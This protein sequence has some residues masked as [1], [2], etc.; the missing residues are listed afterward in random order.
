SDEVD[1]VL[2]RALEK[3]FEDARRPAPYLSSCD[4]ELSLKF[5]SERVT[6]GITATN[7]G[8][9]GPQGRV[10]RLGLRDGS[11]SGKIESFSHKGRTISNL[12]METAGIY[13]L[14]KLLGHRA[15][16]LNAIIANRATGKFSS[17]PTA[18]TDELIRFTLERL[19][20]KK[21]I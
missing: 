12:E 6:R 17:D 9:Y 20:P 3:Y 10:L 21:P 14:S 8:F 15:V 13:G 19:A 18:L 4:N 7:S 2:L 11:L 16:S 5:S 1:P